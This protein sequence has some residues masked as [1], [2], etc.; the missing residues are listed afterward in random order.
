[1]IE[2]LHGLPDGVLGFRAVGAVEASDYESVLD[3]AIDAAIEAGRAVNLVYVLGEEFERYS[4]GA[5]WQDAR[6]EGKPPKIWGRIA[7]VTD[8]PVIGE[9]IHGIAFL[10]PCEL[11]IFA[12][13]ALD[14]AV[15]WAAEGPQTF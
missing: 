6:L 4:L 2:S 3:P 8:H 1:M 9:I 12:V 13:S 11:H 10:F 5:L 15:A 7:L 14:D